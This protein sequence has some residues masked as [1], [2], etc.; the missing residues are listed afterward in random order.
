MKSEVILCD[1]CKKMVSNKKCIFCEKDLCDNCKI[2]IKLI[3]SL[4]Y[5]PHQESEDLHWSVPKKYDSTYPALL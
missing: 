3:I 2:S 5:A 4:N 1:S